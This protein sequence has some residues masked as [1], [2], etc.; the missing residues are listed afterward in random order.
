[1]LWLAAGGLALAGA[2]LLVWQSGGYSA[3]VDRLRHDVSPALFL[4][5]MGVL[6]A[7]GFP[8]SP[9]LILAGLKFGFLTGTGITAVTTLLHLSCAMVVARV[10][11]PRSVRR[12]LERRKRHLPD[13]SQRGRYGPVWLFVVVPGLPYSLKNY[14]LALSDL[15]LPAY[16]GLTW[17][18]QMLIALPFIA[19]GEAA[20]GMQWVLAGGVLLIGAAA[21]LLRRRLA[22][23]RD[24]NPA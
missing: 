15:P 19:F 10:L 16:L 5:F 14:L 1:M 3:L 12:W 18:G 23:R 8:I 7:A 9:F 24:R 2:A 13:L 6:P 17:S 4:V 11:P 20:G 21:W 22:G